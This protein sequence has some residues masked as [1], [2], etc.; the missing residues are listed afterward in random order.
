MKKIIL[1]LVLPLTAVIALDFTMT[2]EG[3]FTN[4]TPPSTSTT[5]SEVSN[6]YLEPVNIPTYD[7]NNPSHLLITLSNGKWTSAYLNN[8]SYKHF[9]IEAGDYSA[10]TIILTA[11][12][13][14]GDRRTISLHNGNDTHPAALAESLQANVRLKW[15]NADYWSIDRLSHIDG[16]NSDVNWFY[17]GASNNIVNRLNMKRYYYGITI[18][19]QSNYNTIQNSYIDHMTHAGRASDNVGIAL[20]TSGATDVITVGTKIINND[21]RNAGDGIQLVISVVGS[22]IDYAGTIIDSNMIWFDND[23]YTNGAGVYDPNGEYMAAENAMDFKTASQDSANPVIVSNNIMW[24]ARSSD[25]VILGNGQ[26]SLSVSHGDHTKHLKI[27]GNI[28]HD[29]HSAHGT[30]GTMTELEFTNNIVF[31]MNAPN[32]GERFLEMG[33]HYDGTTTIIEN[34][35]YIDADTGNWFNYKTQSSLSSFNNNVVIDITAINTP[36]ASAAE[37]TG[38]YYYNSVKKLPKTGTEFVD[39]G[40][41]NMSDYTY[42]YERF[43]S[44]PKSKI[45]KGVITTID[46]PHSGNAGSSIMP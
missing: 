40:N 15:N 2:T 11:D 28:Y 44:S 4:T 13:T 37:V 18:S 1:L 23:I 27:R 5:I 9:Y 26:G 31:N 46:S 33:F 34:N 14:S 24:G 20:I 43:T 6:S 19:H 32:P 22:A 25:P 12:G 10:S 45:L 17:N 29:S 38:N 36:K 8:L 30:A 41:T 39:I 42:K 3:L 16:A 21:I 35:S 7:S